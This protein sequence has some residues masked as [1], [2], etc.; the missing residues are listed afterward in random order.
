MLTNGIAAS[1]V[2]R[3]VHCLVSFGHYGDMDDMKQLLAP[4]LSLLDGRNDK[5]YPTAAGN[6]WSCRFTPHSN[7]TI[8]VPDLW[9]YW[10]FLWLQK[11]MIFSL[12][13]HL[14]TWL[15]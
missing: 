8:D 14:I 3:L 6:V 4:L 7:Y 5:M 10:L 9:L 2:L 13:L 1:Q 11:F 12:E 15:I